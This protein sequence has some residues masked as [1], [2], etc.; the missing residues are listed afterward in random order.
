MEHSENEPLTMRE[1]LFDHVHTRVRGTEM[2]TI[3]EYPHLKF[4]DLDYY[5]ETLAFAEK[6]GG[7]AL[8]SF[9]RC[10]AEF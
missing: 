6:L 2:A 5:K 10:F 9:K 7:K 3:P 8:E 1:I 4:S